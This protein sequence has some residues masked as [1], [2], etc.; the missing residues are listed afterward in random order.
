MPTDD[1]DPGIYFP[2]PQA[3]LKLAVGEGEG[4]GLTVHKAVVRQVD[5]V[6]I[7][8]CEGDSE[9]L[10]YDDEL[11]TD[12][13]SFLTIRSE[14]LKC[15]DKVQI[16]FSDVEGRAGMVLS[17]T[18]DEHTVRLGCPAALCSPFDFVGRMELPS[19]DSEDD[20]A[21]ELRWNALPDPSVIEPP[22][23]SR[24]YVAGECGDDTLCQRLERAATEEAVL[25]ER[26]AGSSDWNT[27]MTLE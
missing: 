24:E 19:V 18:Q 9:E 26:P 8:G 7:E 1:G 22:G 20:P 15:A 25:D 5:S 11:R 2:N 27:V 3:T 14:E 13:D 6:T 21:H 10:A 23:D 12:N 17:V 16:V 4:E